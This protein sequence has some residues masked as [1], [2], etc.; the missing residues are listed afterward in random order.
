MIKPLSD[1]SDADT[2]EIVAPEQTPQN[3]A[4]FAPQAPQVPSTPPVDPAILAL[5][6]NDDLNVATLARQA[7]RDMPDEGEVIISLH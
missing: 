2:A 1:Q 6:D 7:K 3:F 4:S 5:A